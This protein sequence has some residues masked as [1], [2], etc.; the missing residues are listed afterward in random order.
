MADDDNDY[1][2]WLSE[3]DPDYQEPETS[4]ETKMAMTL[5]A[6]Q[7]MKREEENAEQ[8]WNLQGRPKITPQ[9]AQS[10]NATPTQYGQ[11][12]PSSKGFTYAGN[13]I[14]PPAGAPSPQD[15]TFDRMKASGILLQQGIGGQCEEDRRRIAARL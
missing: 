9:M 13:P 7:A 10:F 12:M 8:L 14:S 11:V 4:H 3:A 6:N 2:G 1:E 5:L 15:Q